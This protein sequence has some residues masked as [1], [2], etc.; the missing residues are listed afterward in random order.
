M[1]GDSGW[2]LGV[3]PEISAAEPAALILPGCRLMRAV[4]NHRKEP[5][6]IMTDNRQKIWES[7]AL[8]RFPDCDPFN[9]LNNARYLDYFINARED[10]LL[11]FHHFNIYE[12][13]RQKGLSW[14]VNKNQI[15]YLKPAYLMETVVIQSALLKMDEKETLVEMRMWSEDKS[16]LKAFLWTTFVHFNIKTQKAEPHAPGLIEAFKPYELPLPATASFEAR[17][18]QVKKMGPAH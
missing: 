11:T 8:I 2:Y 13:A 6:P 7:T 10:H 5:N 3:P 16:T 12:L 9:H 15:V 4:K 1:R 17:L 18:V 14:V